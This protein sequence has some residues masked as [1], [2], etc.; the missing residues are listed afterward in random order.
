MKIYFTYRKRDKIFQQEHEVVKLHRKGNDFNV[1]LKN[2]NG[3]I[4]P[5]FWLSDCGKNVGY[6]MFYKF[7][8]RQMKI[9]QMKIAQRKW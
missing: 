2:K 8:K 3:T 9:A 5:S 4:Y 7:S 6:V 1:F